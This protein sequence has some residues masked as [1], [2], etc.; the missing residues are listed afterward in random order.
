MP[1]RLGAA[2]FAV[3]AMLVLSA[4]AA[5]TT[6]A[7]HVTN[8]AATLTANAHCDSG[9]SCKWYWEWW[10]A[11]GPRSA[12]TKTPAFGPVNGATQDVQL[13]QQISGLTPNTTYRWVFCGSPN[14]GGV[15]ACAGPN[16]KFD[17]TTADPPSDYDT[18]TTL[19]WKTLAE[20]WDGSSWTIQ[21]TPSPNGDG[22]GLPGFN[23]ISCTSATACTAVGTYS[24]NGL[25][26][27]VERWDGSSWTIQTAAVPPGADTAEL[28]GVSCTSATR[29]TAVGVTN[30]STHCCVP[31]AEAWDGTTWTVQPTPSLSG[32]DFQELEGVSCTSAT[33]CTAVGVNISTQTT[34]YAGTL[35]ERWDGTSWTMQS[36]PSPSN[37]GLNGVSCTSATACNAVGGIESSTN[38]ATLAEGWDGTSWTI[39]STPSGGGVLAGVSC[40]SAVAC[41]AVGGGSLA[42]RWD[43]TSWTIQPTPPPGGNLNG[44]SCTSATA[45]TAVGYS[46]DAS[47]NQSTLAERWDGTS[48]TIQPTPDPSSRL[49]RL[50]SVSCTASTACIAAGSR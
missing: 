12:S 7:T 28:S 34:R 8:S 19:P 38:D 18:F 43:G 5:K 39:Q 48:W 31:L 47:F 3:A 2:G 4:C 6:G 14:N 9:Q 40:T 29:C 27:L 11:N 1:R 17:S 46:Q 22:P 42:E 15:Y 41:T 32:G 25:R 20:V 26:P 23:G 50:N 37:S 33:A 49:P 36:T 45:C 30:S 16:G 35:V 21:Q 24:D 13:T 10:P 44:V